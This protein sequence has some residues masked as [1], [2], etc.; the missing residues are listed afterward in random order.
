MQPQTTS[1]TGRGIACWALILVAALAWQGQSLL[2]ALRPPAVVVVDFFQEWA[3]ARNFFNGEPIYEPHRVSSLHYLG[4]APVGDAHYFIEVNAH[5]PTTVLLALPLAALDYRDAVLVWNGISLVAL[6]VAIWLIARQLGYSAGVRSVLPVFAV[7]PLCWPLCSH[8]Q[9]GQ[10]AMIL[11]LL[12]TVGWAAERSGLLRLSGIFLGAATA[13]K[14]F[15]ALLLLPLIVRRQWRIVAWAA[16]GLA[17]ILGVT[18]VLLGPAAHVAYLRDVP[19]VVSEWRSAWNNASLSGLWNKLFNP[20]TKGA[21]VEP[22]IYSPI[23]ARCLV[24]VSWV[25][26]TYLLIRLA[27]KAQLPADY[28]R[29]FAAAITGMLLLTPVTWEHAFLLLLLPLAVLWSAAPAGS[30]QRRFVLVLS[31]VLFLVKPA[32]FYREWEIGEFTSGSR[33]YCSAAH[34][35]ALLS[36]QCYALVGLFV[37]TVWRS[38]TAQAATSAEPT[39]FHAIAVERRAA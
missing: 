11:L 21:G 16:I 27:R 23:L 12:I 7:L 13:I 33:V 3:S 10:L 8:L 29:T 31:V 17:V 6:A 5:P 18:L 4:V 9:Q 1:W 25:F 15:P 22:L 35:L 39:N 2:R 30:M 34:V 19:P 38:R 32:Y 14:V 26:V 24:A 37:M 28:D 36:V 20:G